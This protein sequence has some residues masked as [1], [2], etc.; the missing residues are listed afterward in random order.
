MGVDGEP[1]CIPH[2]LHSGVSK[3]SSRMQWLKCSESS[4][5]LVWLGRGNSFRHV[6]GDKTRLRNW[7]NFQKTTMSFRLLWVH[8]RNRITWCK[9]SAAAKP[10]FKILQRR[11]RLPC[12]RLA[13]V[14][15]ALAPSPPSDVLQ[16]A[17][18]SAAPGTAL[19]RLHLHLSVTSNICW[20]KTFFPPI[21]CFPF[22]S[23]SWNSDTWL[24]RLATTSWKATKK[25][26]NVEGES[27]IVLNESVE[28]FCK[29]N[30]IYKKNQRQKKAGRA[31]GGSAEG[32]KKGRGAS[33]TSDLDSRISRLDS[34]F[35]RVL[36]WLLIT[37]AAL[38]TCSI[39]Y[40][41]DNLF[42]APMFL[43]HY[44]K[45][46][47]CPLHDCIFRQSVIASGKSRCFL[48]DRIWYEVAW[49]AQEPATR[50]HPWG[51]TA[52]TEKQL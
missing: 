36:F 17:D 28:L 42:H 50:K 47:A 11:K 31:R 43:S 12:S 27:L 38:V 35:C 18:F 39:Q 34:K 40:F 49:E 41:L 20:K 44:K 5:K 30:Q 52:S 26:S 15:M 48:Y 51:G 14:G 25:Y 8:K 13:G 10:Y 1:W 19:L 9:S 21:S 7:T 3:C 6:A 45:D 22:I 16:R 2:A 4:L 33:G 46:F 37:S 24:E 32:G 23:L 29:S